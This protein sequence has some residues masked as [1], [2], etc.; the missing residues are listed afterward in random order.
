M[1]T[2]DE[3]KENISV[4]NETPPDSIPEVELKLYRMVKQV[5]EEELKVNCTA[6]WLLSTLSP[7]CGYTSMLHLIQSETYV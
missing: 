2:L 4:T 7:E 3:V 1:G 6:M 5:Y